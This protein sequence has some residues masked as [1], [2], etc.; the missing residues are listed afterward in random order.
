M[1]C[2]LFFFNIDKGKKLTNNLIVQIFLEAKL[3]EFCFKRC[4]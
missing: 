1:F 3:G 2:D 4:Y